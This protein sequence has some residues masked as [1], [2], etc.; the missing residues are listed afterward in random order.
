MRD[1]VTPKLTYREDDAMSAVLVAPFLAVIAA[2]ALA[3]AWSV[4]RL[5]SLWR[6]KR[7]RSSRQTSA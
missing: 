7:V 6:P 3:A 2:V 4:R 1:D 5:G